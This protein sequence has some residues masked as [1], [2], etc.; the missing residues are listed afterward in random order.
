MHV[1]HHHLDTPTKIHRSTYEVMIPTLLLSMA[2]STRVYLLIVALRLSALMNLY[3]HSLEGIF[4]PSHHKIYSF[5]A[6]IHLL[7]HPL[8]T[9]GSTITLSK[10]IHVTSSFEVFIKTNLIV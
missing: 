4:H 10:Y 6:P 3:I 2:C 1:R 9:V 5:P 8:S 7:Y